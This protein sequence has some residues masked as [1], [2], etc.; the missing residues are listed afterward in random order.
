MR[1]WVRTGVRKANLRTR[2]CAGGCSLSLGFSRVVEEAPDTS[3]W[4]EVLSQ[5][6][7]NNPAS[8]VDLFPG[9]FVCSGGGCKT[10]G[11]WLFCV[12]V[13]VGVFEDRQG[14]GGGKRRKRP[15]PPPLPTHP[16]PTHTHTNDP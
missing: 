8:P 6:Q 10:P 14:G 4:N 12:C 2:M 1:L 13:C 15:L 11:F 9:L 3:K 16:P 5:R 7:E